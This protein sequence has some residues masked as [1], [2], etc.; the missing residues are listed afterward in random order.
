MVQVEG[1]SLRP[2]IFHRS[3][4]LPGLGSLLIDATSQF[5]EEIQNLSGRWQVL[6]S[7]V[8][9]GQGARAGR[10]A[11]LTA[12]LSLSIRTGSLPGSQ[13][14]HLWVCWVRY[15]DSAF[16]YPHW[17]SCFQAKGFMQS[18]CWLEPVS[19]IAQHCFSR[20]PWVVLQDTERLMSLRG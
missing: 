5:S 20:I 16:S 19:F 2:Q 10:L 14:S 7:E 8:G 18:G 3:Y 15:L 12:L 9:G 17:D 11:L 6:V 4:A 13:H 1:V